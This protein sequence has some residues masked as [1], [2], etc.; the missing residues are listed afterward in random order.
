MIPLQ[1]QSDQL[2]KLKEERKVMQQTVDDAETELDTMP[3]DEEHLHKSRKLERLIAR[4]NAEIGETNQYIVDLTANIIAGGVT[5]G[6]TP[7]GT[8]MRVKRPCPEP[9]TVPA[10]FPDEQ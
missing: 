4:T 3:L 1:V 7:V 2:L 10:L 5:P 8:P 6:S 9:V